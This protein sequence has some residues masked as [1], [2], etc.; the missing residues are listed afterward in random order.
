MI[1]R[2]FFNGINGEAGGVTITGTDQGTSYVLADIAEARL[3]R[4]DLAVARADGAQDFACIGG[5]PPAGGVICNSSD[6]PLS[7]LIR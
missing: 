6:P 1:Q 2:F 5:L 7:P 3:S 4:A